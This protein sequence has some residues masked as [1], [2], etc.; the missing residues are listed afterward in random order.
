MAHTTL[1]T[2]G[3]IGEVEC[4]K[5]LLSKK[6]SKLGNTSELA[7]LWVRGLTGIAGVSLLGCG[8]IGIDV[9]FPTG[10]FTSG[11]GPDI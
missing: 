4:G 1:V 9:L 8:Q 10:V 7:Y 5:S 3:A 6:A 11:L 2:L